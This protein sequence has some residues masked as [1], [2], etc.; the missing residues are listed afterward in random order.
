M[1]SILLFEGSKGL[2]DSKVY[3]LKGRLNILDFSSRKLKIK[4]ILEPK[5]LQA[6]PN[7]PYLNSGSKLV[8]M[9]STELHT[10]K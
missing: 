1:A 4:N 9:E 8:Q 3:L 2:Q 5:P 6:E 10:A 7:L